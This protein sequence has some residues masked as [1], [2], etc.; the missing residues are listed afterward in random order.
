MAYLNSELPA[1]HRL[2]TLGDILKYQIG[3]LDY[4][5]E[6]FTY[7]SIIQKAKIEHE[8][9]VWQQVLNYKYI[10]LKIPMGRLFYRQYLYQ[11][12]LDSALNS[13]NKKLNFKPNHFQAKTHSNG[14][15]HHQKNNTNHQ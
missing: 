3:L 8:I 4:L 6:N 9:M 14:S 15:N 11:E 1:R 7:L 2:I 10:I 12:D 13:E 5:E